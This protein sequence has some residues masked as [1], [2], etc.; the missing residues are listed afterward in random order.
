MTTADELLRVVTQAKSKT[1]EVINDELIID[2]ETRTITVP[3]TERLFGVEGDVNI[4]R[5][6][7]RC[8][9][10]VGDNI[11]LSAHN[12]YIAYVFTDNQN[13]SFFPTVGIGVYKCEDVTVD[14][15][16]ITFS[17]KLSGNVFER[18]GFIAFKMYAK[19]SDDDYETVFN[20]TPAIGTV[21][22]TIPYGTD[23]IV[24]RYPDVID[25]IFDRL[26]ALESGG[27]GGTGGTTNYNNLSNKPQLN[28]VTLEGNKTLDQVG[29]LAKNQGASN[30]GK[31]LS[32]GSDGN[33][34]PA[35]APSGG[36][37][38]S[39]TPGKDGR[40]IQIQ[41]NGTAIQWRYVG[42]VSW[43][44][45]VQLSDIT[46]A[47]GDP[48]E[49]GITPTIREN[50]NWYL[51]EEDT[52]KPSRGEKGN[53]G[54]KGDPGPTGATPNIQIG[55]VQTLEPG[56]QA[57]ASMTGTPENPLLN[58]GIPKG[59]TGGGEGGGGITEETDPTV[60]AWAKEPTKPTYTAV[61]VGADASG[62]AEAK[63]SVHNTA[64]DAHSDIRLSVQELT[65]RLNALADSDDD[66][67]DQMSEIVAYIKSNKSLI[68][69]IT[70][71]K[72]SVTDIIDNLTT[73][74][75]NKPLSAAQGVALKALIDGIT[76]PETLPNPQKIIFTGAVTAEY[77][78]SSQQTINI[79]TGGSDPYTLPIMSS[80]QLGG[81]KAIEK[82][83]E[84][85]PV[86]VD[87]LT[88]QLFVPTYPESG[89]GA[90]GI[91]VSYDAEQQAIVFTNSSGRGN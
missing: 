78:G 46:G 9:K 91:T 24:E 48:G 77:D 20:T 86:A 81:G 54:D 71:Q 18:P 83:D 39:G 64:V 65:T 5:K 21:L 62:T 27:G 56:Q 84:D 67:L 40:E 73:N 89:S 6:H 37:G 8:P 74:V 32:V 82:T 33:V 42:D 69:A 16:D 85:V 38:G 23:E 47:K 41:N 13:S 90:S 51:G 3:D 28:G 50:G 72:V 59:A 35:D 26:D 63:V 87:S 12:I 11:D 4:E 61:E 1:S 57:T 2:G 10:I 45:L 53:P 80:T 14:D 66:T 55:T 43:T 31:Y 29:V 34:V 52:G 25:Q 30:S 76:I 7:F 15:N 17:W 58:L 68:D 22:M 49:D 60:P 36:G 19:K 75:A 88:G 79:P 70:T 44:D